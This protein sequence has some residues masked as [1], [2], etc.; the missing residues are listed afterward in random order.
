MK[1][2]LE[3]EPRSLAILG[4]DLNL[5][6]KELAQLRGLP[7]GFYDVWE[8]CGEEQEHKYTW[9]SS[10]PRFRLDRLLCCAGD[11][12]KLRPSLF[13]LVGG[14]MVQKCG[15]LYPSDHLGLWAEFELQS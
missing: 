1:E 3:R 15:D 13:Q 7:N 9:E 12:V 11:D 6:D 5:T 4:G 8:Q 14:E 2:E 10:E